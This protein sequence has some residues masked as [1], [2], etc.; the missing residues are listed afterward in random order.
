LATLAFWTDVES[1]TPPGLL[2]G[3]KKIEDTDPNWA[4]TA[5]PKAGI[6]VENTVFFGV[7]FVSRAC[8]DIANRLGRRPDLQPERRGGVSYLASCLVGHDGRI[9]TGSFSPTTFALRFEVLRRR[10]P[11]PTHFE[12]RRTELRERFEDRFCEFMD[13]GGE[14]SLGSSS[15]AVSGAKP[16]AGGFRQAVRGSG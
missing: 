10:H 3:A 15:L 2:D 5:K 11:T 7:F 8:E 13:E 14:R 9:R 12:E 4:G 16:R 1:L 6:R